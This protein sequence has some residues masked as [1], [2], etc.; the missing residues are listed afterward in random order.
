[1]HLG[2]HVTF[3]KR[4][5][6]GWPSKVLD[7]EA[8]LLLFEHAHRQLYRGSVGAPMQAAEGAASS[9]IKWPS[10]PLQLFS[11]RAVCFILKKSFKTVQLGSICLQVLGT[12]GGGGG[13]TF[14]CVF[15]MSGLTQGDSMR[16]LRK[17]TRCDL[18]WHH[19]LGILGGGACLPSKY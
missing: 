17:E 18:L 12:G 16:F 11:R 1:M 5:E 2:L 10:H 6:R 9:A 15:S 14:L 13:D 19:G 8:N 3:S 7:R 4:T